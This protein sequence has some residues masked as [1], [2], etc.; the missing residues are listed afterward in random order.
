MPENINPWPYSYIQQLAQEATYEA[1]RQGLR[2]ATAKEV[3]RNFKHSNRFN[4]PFLG[5]YIPEGWEE[6]VTGNL[7]FVDTT[8]RGAVGSA[9]T[10]FEFYKRAQALASGSEVFGFGVVEQGQFQALVATYRRKESNGKE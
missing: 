8:G 2:P 1:E 6:V 5:D 7:L 4:I 10:Q 3:I 9:I